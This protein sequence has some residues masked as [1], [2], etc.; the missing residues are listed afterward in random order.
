MTFEKNYF[1][2]DGYNKMISEADCTKAVATIY[3]LLVRKV[4]FVAEGKKMPVEE[5]KALVNLQV[6]LYNE[7]ALALKKSYDDVEALIKQQHKIAKHSTPNLL[8]PSCYC[9]A[10]L[11]LAL[12]SS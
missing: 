5:S 2:S 12:I 10:F 11:L 7:L 4:Q 8:R 9:F 3:S 6:I 1:V